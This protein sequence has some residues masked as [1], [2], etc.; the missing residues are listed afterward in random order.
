MILVLKAIFWICSFIVFYSYFGYALLSYLLVKIL[1]RPLPVFDKSFIPEV[2]I[3]IAAYNEKDFITDKIKNTLQLDYPP[4]KLQIIV[5]TDGS[6]DGTEQLIKEFPEV[7]HLHIPERNGK[8]AAVDRAMAF[9]ETSF[10][11]FTDANTFINKDAIKKIIRHFKSDKVG[12]VAGEKRVQNKKQGGMIAEGEGLYWKYESFLKKLDSQL[13]SVVG[14]AGELYAIRKELYQSVPKDTIIEDFYLTLKIAAGG[15]KI[16]Y[17]PEAFSIESSSVSV[18]EELKRKIRIAAGGIQSIIRLKN[19][20]NP[21]RYGLLSFQYI[22]HR[23][24]RWTLAPLSIVLIFISNYILAYYQIPF[25]RMI[26]ILQSIFYIM[27]TLGMFLE[28]SRVRIKLFFIPFYF[29]IMNYAVY[30]GFLRHLKGTQSVLWEKAKR[31][32]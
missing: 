31:E 20:L 12:G 25:Y 27:A 24:L 10:V 13:Y 28:N 8:I 11:I 6:D 16:V 22:S 1:R 30:V 23:V 17:E 5:V 7:K 29:L 21:F 9:V 19:L 14:A 2:S 32:L 15:F 18:P 4:D 3:I 26:F